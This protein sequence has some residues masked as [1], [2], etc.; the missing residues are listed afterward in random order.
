[1]RN[2]ILVSILTAVLVVGSAAVY[3]QPPVSGTWKST[4]GDFDEGREANSWA[5]GDFVGMGNVLHAESWDGSALGGDWKI[6]CPIVSSVTL[7]ADLVFNG[8]GHRIYLIEYSSGTIVLDGAGPWGGGDAQYTGLITSYF[9]T[10]TLQFVADQNQ[11]PVFV[12]SVSDHA[13]SAQLQ[14]YTQSCMTWGIGN[15]VWLG[16]GAVPAGYPDYRDA[17][18][19]SGGSGHYGDISDLT[20]S[21]QGCAVSTEESSWGRVKALYRD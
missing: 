9:E 18:C 16:N 8:N 5:A 15:G 20:L 21:V 12:G 14:G 2:A 4:D 6:L 17:G 3:A 19:A 10:R 7:L 1:M 11:Q 13:V